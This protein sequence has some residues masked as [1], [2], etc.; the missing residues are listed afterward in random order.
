MTIMIKISLLALFVLAFATPHSQLLANADAGLDEAIVRSILGDMEDE[1]KKFRDEIERAFMLRCDS[2]TLSDCGSNNYNDCSSAFPNPTCSKI[3]TSDCG[4]GCELSG[5]TLY[6]VFLYAGL[7]SLLIV[8]TPSLNEYYY[9]SVNIDTTISKVTVPRALLPS[10]LDPDQLQ[11][12]SPVDHEVIQTACYTRLVEPYM[13]DSYRRS[14]EY[15]KEY[16]GK[17][18]SIYFGAHNG[19]F[20]MV[21]AK[22]QPTCWDFDHRFRPWCVAASSGPKDVVLVLD[23]SASM[24]PSAEQ[25]LRLKKAKEAATTVIDTLTVSDKVAIV[26]FNG[27]ASVLTLA[28]NDN[29]EQLI[30]A[31]NENKEQLK[32][33]INLLEADGATNFYD[34][35]D[36]TFR[37]LS[38]SFRDEAYAAKGSG[39]N[40]AVIFLTDGAIAEYKQGEELEAETERVITLVKNRTAEIETDYSRKTTVFGYSLG[41]E[42]DTDVMKQIACQTNGI[43]T[44]ITDD[45]ADNLISEM[46]AYY[47]LFAAGL[48]ASENNKDFVA[49]VEPYTFKS[50]GKLGTTVSVPVFDRSVT[51]YVRVGV[52][53][54]DVYMEPLQAIM[55]DRNV[56]EWMKNDFIVKPAEECPTIEPTQCQLD[57]LSSSRGGIN[58]TCGFCSN[59]EGLSHT[60]CSTQTESVYSNGL[61]KYDDCKCC[62][63]CHF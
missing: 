54:I 21:P 61:W 25:S 17:P 9:R 59:Y 23:I 7:L 33:K 55:K 60:P 10:D 57:A 12:A 43:W 4:C 51:P 24:A 14:E 53:G 1:V 29:K 42:S 34:A 46:G 50:D 47:Q 30:V 32:E 44:H 16:G 52:A 20:R 49:W 2:D 3:S 8:V 28:S 56:T 35:F 11:T 19:L 39:C 40:V 22:H 58:A 38:D 41:D 45:E 31:S 37:V 63:F 5:S 48:G 13:V 27:N 26:V 6:L 62:M 36:V 18:G 15:W